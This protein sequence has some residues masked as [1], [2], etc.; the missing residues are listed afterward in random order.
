MDGEEQKLNT[1]AGGRSYSAEELELLEIYSHTFI[2]SYAHTLDGKGRLVVPQ[3]FR[4]DLGKTFYICPSLDFRSISLYTNLEWAKMRRH[5][6]ELGAINAKFQK[7]LELFD[8]L[9]YRD[10]E[11]DAQGRVL[12]PTKIR[13]LILKEEKEVE[14]S[15]ASDHI[16]VVAATT[17][18]ELAREVLDN[19]D[20]FT[21]LFSELSEMLRNGK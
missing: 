15:G 14:I 18:E 8:A 21:A 11:C 5:Y 13:Q 7:F 3:A 6:G 12:L 1:A 20:S 17:S 19:R 9:S 16:R 4:D 10:Q 2:G